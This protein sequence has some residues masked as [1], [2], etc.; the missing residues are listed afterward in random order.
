[1]ETA[2]PVSTFK[3]RTIR[4]SSS[5]SSIR[6]LAASP[7]TSALAPA[8]VQTGDDDDAREDKARTDAI[9]QA[10]SKKTAAGRV[11]GREVGR[12]ASRL[13][14]GGGAEEAEVR[15]AFVSTVC[16][17]VGWNLVLTTCDVMVME[18]GKRCVVQYPAH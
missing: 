18:G 11:Q 16:F 12:K 17:T 2:T 1:M 5:S 3:K 14:F 6:S 4:P 15:F 10:R 8:T 13:S 7:S 9:A